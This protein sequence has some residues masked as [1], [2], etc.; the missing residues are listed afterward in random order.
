MKLTKEYWEDRYQQQQTAWDIGSISTPLKE[1]IDQLTD[2]SLSILIP[3]GGNSYEL[4]YL[5]ENGFESVF[6]VDFATTP[7][8]YI[9]KRIPHLQ[10]EQLIQ[11]DFFELEGHFDLI[12]EQTFF[13]ALNPYLREKYV[14]KVK[15]LL[16]PNG[17]VAGVFF[18]F[19]LTEVGPPFGGSKTEYENLFRTNFRI[20]SLE[21][22]Y[23]S[24][25]P[26]REN[27]LFFIFEKK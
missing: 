18:Q 15:S 12:L 27:E 13:C 17:K 11:A 10:S 25:K 7:L 19:P 6:V 16:K 24:I 23:N 22:A 8:H 26:R 5:L 14:E 2:K 20:K 1:Y 21:T 9:R 4:E 3:G